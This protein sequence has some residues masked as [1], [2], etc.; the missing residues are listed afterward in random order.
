MT[1]EAFYLELTNFFA[2][3]NACECRCF[4]VSCAR[5]LL[6]CP[7][8]TCTP[9]SMTG[10]SSSSSATAVAQAISS[11]NSN[12]VSQVNVRRPNIQMLCPSLCK[13]IKSASG[14]FSAFKTGSTTEF[15]SHLISEL[16]ALSQAISQGNSASLAQSFAQAISNGETESSSAADC[17]PRPIPE[18][19][20]KCLK[21]KCLDRCPNLPVQILTWRKVLI[22]QETLELFCGWL[23]F[24]F[25]CIDCLA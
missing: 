20:K 23:R 6:Q 1:G 7:T 24:W 17:T 15:L 13:L 4:A 8:G 21:N 14:R 3:T 11:G 19:A 9:S 25:C 5:R 12:A 16:Q 2:I 10:G 22:S 18:P